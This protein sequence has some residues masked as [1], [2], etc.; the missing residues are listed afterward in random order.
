MRNLPFATRIF[1]SRYKTFLTLISNKNKTLNTSETNQS[2]IAQSVIVCDLQN[3]RGKLFRLLKSTITDTIGAIQLWVL[4]FFYLDSIKFTTTAL[5][6]GREAV[7][8]SYLWLC[9]K[10]CV[11][12]YFKLTTLFMVKEHIM[13]TPT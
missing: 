10:S 2:A 12:L 13:K 8:A 4:Y 1:Q 7:V 3:D 5:N 6:T 9:K 11:T